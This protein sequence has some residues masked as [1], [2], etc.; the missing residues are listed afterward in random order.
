MKSHK[1]DLGVL[2]LCLTYVGIEEG[3]WTNVANSPVE[4]G[5]RLA[6]DGYQEEN[7]VGQSS[8]IPSDRP[9]ADNMKQSNEEA[10]KL[11][12]KCRNTLEVMTVLLSNIRLF[13]RIMM[14]MCT[15]EPLQI[16]FDRNV[17]EFKK[18]TYCVNER[19]QMS[20]GL[21]IVQLMMDVFKTLESGDKVRKIDF[22]Y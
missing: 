22:S 18:P 2:L 21:G 9:N 19:I 4:R 1:N 16:H 6:L 8:G 3:F 7:P 15:V 13:R 20:I 10:K 5:L 14:I 17:S 12:K 11:F